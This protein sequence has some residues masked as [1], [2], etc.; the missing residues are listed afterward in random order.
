[1]HRQLGKSM[2]CDG[3]TLWL[4]KMFFGYISYKS[5]QIIYQSILFYIIRSKANMKTSFAVGN[6]QN[7]IFFQQIAN[8]SP[9]HSL[10]KMV[11]EL[12]FCYKS[13]KFHDKKVIK[14]N[15]ESYYDL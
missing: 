9:R 12:I 1:M 6:N 5:I 3:G 10:L 8:L 15:L 13:T 4:P 14:Q 2:F 11:P 7:Y